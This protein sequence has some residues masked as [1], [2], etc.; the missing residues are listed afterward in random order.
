MFARPIF[1]P[2]G[3]W[4]LICGRHNSKE[5]SC[6]GQAGGRGGERRCFRQE[7]ASGGAVVSPLRIEPWVGTASPCNAV[8]WSRGGTL[9]A[10]GH[11]DGN[12]RLWDIASGHEL[13]RPWHSAGLCRFEPGELD[14][15]THRAPGRRPKTSIPGNRSPS[16]GWCP[17]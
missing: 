7:R 10:T 16:R 15:S 5:A 13:R 14:S 8:A 11:D 2:P 3:S 6:G 17:E 12:L 1:R 9:L 4:E